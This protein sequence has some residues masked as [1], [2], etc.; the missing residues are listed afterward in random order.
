MTVPVEEVHDGFI[1]LDKSLYFHPMQAVI[2]ETPPP[3]DT[4]S[5]TLHVS[6]GDT[7]RWLIDK[8]FSDFQNLANALHSA[9]RGQRKLI[10][11]LPGTH[12]FKATN[13]DPALLDERRLGLNR[14]LE[15]L[16][17]SDLAESSLVVAFLEVPPACPQ[18]VLSSA[19]LRHMQA[20]FRWTCM[21]HVLHLRRVEPTEKLNGS[22]IDPLALH[23]PDSGTGA[24]SREGTPFFAG[25]VEDMGFK[26]PNTSLTSQA[27][28]CSGVSLRPT[29]LGDSSVSSDEGQPDCDAESPEWSEMAALHWRGLSQFNLHHSL[30][31]GATRFKAHFKKDGGRVRVA[32]NPMALYMDALPCPQAFLGSGVL[33]SADDV[34]ICRGLVFYDA[35]HGPPAPGDDR[36]NF[37][38][39]TLF[40]TDTDRDYKKFTQVANH[41]RC[42]VQDARALL[43]VMQLY[44]PP[45][46]RELMAAALEEDAAEEG[47][48]YEI[49]SWVD[50][51]LHRSSISEERRK[52]P[53]GDGS[54][55]S[56]ASE[57]ADSPT[58]AARAAVELPSEPVPEPQSVHLRVVDRDLSIL[59]T[60]TV[61]SLLVRRHAGGCEVL[62]LGLNEF[63]AL[64]GSKFAL[65]TWDAFRERDEREPDR[66][67][68]DSPRSS[69]PPP[70][71]KGPP[72]LPD[73]GF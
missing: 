38:L 43:K 47:R 70:G 23:D 2:P 51:E 63:V 73:F 65:H 17:R 11:R 9:C 55:P 26:V 69:I 54:P 64:R 25:D 3:G 16:L 29:T 31:W 7:H 46:A 44:D 56:Y 53:S 35:R 72:G 21:A 59:L 42:K 49:G 32:M 36:D 14:F 48:D 34:Q 8:R 62:F 28:A 37:R 71:P 15:E 24:G 39:T 58:S 57:K 6:Q 4:V 60:F 61:Y 40:R 19:A 27:W 12:L 68:E 5:Y 13:R 10:P 66:R 30:R 41:L 67:E 1:V 18:P 33:Y 50:L 52:P 20:G 45:R 22:F